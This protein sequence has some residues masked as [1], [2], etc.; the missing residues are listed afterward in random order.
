MN[1]PDYFLSLV[2]HDHSGK[3]DDSALCAGFERGKWRNNQ[4]ADHVME[5]LPEFA[6]SHSELKEI[7]HHNAV[8][9]TKKAARIIYQTDKYGSRGE[10][11]ELL[12]HIAIRQIYKTIPAI[13]KIYYKSSVNKTVEGFDAVHVVKKDQHLELWIGETKFY[14]DITRA[15]DDVCDEII[16]HLETDY[17]KNEFILIRNKIDPAWPEANS[18]NDL[19][20]GNH[21][22]DE[23]FKKACI[24][25]LLTY[26]SDV[27]RNTSKSDDEYLDNIRK[28]MSAAF[29]KMRMK[30]EKKYEAQFKEKLPLTVHVI[31]IPLHEKVA[32]VTALHSKLKALQ[33]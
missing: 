15:I 12:L 3:G 7:G 16:T 18:L 6:L 13:S 10:F 33:A 14:N 4:L 26:D 32:L 27:V 17:L 29:K 31:F 28:E 22:L 9:L 2:L 5:W 1:H 30:L 19:L 25:V 24:P 21:S 23:V 11:G 8:R 20:D